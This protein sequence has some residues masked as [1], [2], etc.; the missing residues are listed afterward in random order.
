MSEENKPKKNK[1]RKK[2]LSPRVRRIRLSSLKGGGGG[3]HSDKADHINSSKNIDDQLNV[4]Y[5]RDDGDIPDMEHFDRRKKGSVVGAFLTLFFTCA[6]LVVVIWLGFFVFDPHRSFSEEDVI[7]S[8]SGDERVGIGESV[9]YRI[10]YR[11]DQNIDLHDVGISVKYPMGFQVDNVTVIP[12]DDTK[13]E[14]SL[15]VLSAG[16]S[17]FIDIVGRV[18]GNLEDRQSFRVFLNYTPD[19]FRSEFQKVATLSIQLVETPYD[20]VIKGPDQIIPGRDVEYK[21]KVRRL[22]GS[23]IKDIEL[24]VLGG[25]N[26][27]VKNSFPEPINLD[28]QRWKIIFGSDDTADFNIT[29]VF[30]KVS[31]GE[32]PEITFAVVGWQN[33]DKSGDMYVYSRKIHSFELLGNTVVSRV[34]INGA[35]KVADV[36]PGEMMN[37]S[38]SFK[39]ESTFYL[40]D[41]VARVI[42]DSPYA[43]DDKS[44]I[45]WEKIEDSSKGIIVGEQLSDKRR[46]GSVTWSENSINSLKAVAPNEEFTIDFSLPLKDGRIVSLSTYEESQIK[47]VFEVVYIQKEEKEITSSLPLTLNIISDAKIKITDKVTESAGKEV[48]MIR[49]QINNTFHNL[50]NI[51]VSADLYGDVTLDVAMVTSTYGSFVYDKPSGKLTWTIGSINTTS[52]DVYVE[53]PVTVNTVNPSQTNLTSKTMFEARDVV[54]DTKILK[55]GD[56]VLLN[57]GEIIYVE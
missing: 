51:K 6:L 45:D 40:R 23:D 29:G 4:I 42:F 7:V 48:H 57:E 32:I 39:N 36:E 44:I 18:Y 12:V 25:D 35:D 52:T 56:A 31:D 22:G 53:F 15:G 28:T 49:W 43:K 55:I 16:D 24:A 37:I 20:I 10:R 27:K 38:V 47:V 30:S 8:I 11:N 17:G 26:F 50:S 33:S 3:N 2:V 19:N 21:V 1:T 5:G 46:R 9:R 13:D 41:V 34:I 54:L 14:W